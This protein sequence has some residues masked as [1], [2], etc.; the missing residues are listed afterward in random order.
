MNVRHQF[1][2][3]HI[4]VLNSM[5]AIGDEIVNGATASSVFGWEKTFEALFQSSA[6]NGLARTKASSNPT[7]SVSMKHSCQAS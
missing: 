4:I 5:V 3:L 7:Q 6:F 1:D 2:D